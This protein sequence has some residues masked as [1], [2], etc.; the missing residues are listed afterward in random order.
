MQKE[1][2][3]ERFT[4]KKLDNFEPPYKMLEREALKSIVK[5]DKPVVWP[6][7]VILSVEISITPER[8]ERITVRENEDVAEIAATFCAKHDLDKGM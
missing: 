2:R 1:A 4:K 6:G 5:K 8:T 3:G 7:R